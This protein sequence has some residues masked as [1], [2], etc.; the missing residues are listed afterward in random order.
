M[1]PKFAK[2]T[3]FSPLHKKNNIRADSGGGLRH[4]EE[5]AGKARKRQMTEMARPVGGIFGVHRARFR[6]VFAPVGI[7][8]MPSATLLRG[9][10]GRRTP[11]HI[12][13][14]RASRNEQPPRQN[15]IG[16]SV[17]AIFR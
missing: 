8:K 13:T 5:G 4:Q 3:N 14:G 9:N 16:F 2:V 12:S 15:V 6:G 1:I 17:D 10:R 7:L 11:F